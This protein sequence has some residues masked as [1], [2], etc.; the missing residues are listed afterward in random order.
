M[1]IILAIH[2]IRTHG[3]WIK[4]FFKYVKERQPTNNTVFVDYNYGWLSAIF[5][6]IPFVKFWY[7]KKLKRKIREIQKIYPL[8]DLN[9]VAHSYGTEL[10][11]W[12]LHSSGED[13]RP[14]IK[15]DK[16]IFSGSILRINTDFSQ[17]F[18]QDKI[19]ELHNYS[20]L[21]DEVSRLNPFGHSGYTKLADKNV[22]NHQN[23]TLEHCGYFVE[24]YY[25]E[26][27]DI[28]YRVDL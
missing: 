11:Y 1:K 22:I 5:C 25:K 2:G 24:Q 16:I 23:N 14:I 12:A 13:G 4:E 19:K 7:V 10:T 8:A 9:I 3:E 26:W 15:T 27:Y 21:E 6:V 18:E 17:E 20:S 28:I